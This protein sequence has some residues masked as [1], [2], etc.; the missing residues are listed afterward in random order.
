[1]YY[2]QEICTEGS[3]SRNPQHASWPYSPACPRI[4]GPLSYLPY[5]TL[6]ANSVK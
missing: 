2:L 5:S 1:M 6:S 4:P 3:G